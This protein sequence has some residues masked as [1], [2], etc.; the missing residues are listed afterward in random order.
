M[1]K[2][3]T[4]AVL[5]LLGDYS[6]TVSLHLRDIGVEEGFADIW[7]R[8]FF[9][10]FPFQTVLRIMDVFLLYG[11]GYFWGISEVFQVRKRFI[12]WEQQF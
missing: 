5:N 9:V 10:G 12:E 2:Y 7:F 4:A 11:K 3:S 1:C 6:N 8:R